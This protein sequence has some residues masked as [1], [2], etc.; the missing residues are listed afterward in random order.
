MIPDVP[1]DVEAVFG[2]P[3]GLKVVGFAEPNEHAPEIVGIAVRAGMDRLTGLVVLRPWVQRAFLDPE[4]ILA[5]QAEVEG[6]DLGWMLWSNT[7][8]FT[9]EMLP[10]VEE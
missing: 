2:F 7:A 6:H 3:S 4:D 8:D 5:V 9:I 10:G 1:V